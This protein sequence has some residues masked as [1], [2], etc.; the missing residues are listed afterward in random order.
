MLEAIKKHLARIIIGLIVV[1]VFLVHTVSLWGLHIPLLDQFESIIYDTRLRLTMPEGVD[2]RI[3]ILDIDEKSLAE[4]EKG[5]EG[6]WPWPRDRLAAMVDKLFDKYQVAVVG[7]DVVFAERD[8]SSG[9]RVLERLGARELR[10][11]PEFHSVLKEVKPQLEYDDIFARKMRGRPV[12]MGY[13]FSSEE[14]GLAPKKGMLP[15]PIFT[16]ESF[17]G[18][19]VGTLSWTGYTANLDVLQRSA[20]SAGHFNSHTDSDG[21]V[22]RVPMLAEYGG[23]YYEPLSLAMV[24]VL[25]GSPPVKAV[26]PDQAL[27]P[28]GYPDLEWLEVGSLRIPVDDT[29]S[30]LVPYRGRKGSFR[31]YS[32]VDVM[33]ERIDPAELK[34]KIALVGTTA[35]GLLDLRATPVDAVYPGVEVHANMIAGMLDGNIKQRPPYVLG[36]EFMLLL[37][38]GLLLALVLPFVNPLKAT[39]ITLLVLSAVLAGNLTVFEHGH[40]VLPLASGLVMVLLLFTLNMAYGFFIEARGTR[41]ITGL[42]GQYV[43]PELVERMA[44]N[45]EQFS[46]APRAEELSVLFSDVRGFT[47]IS[48]ALTPEDL[49]HYINEYLTTMSLV[50]REQHRGTLDKYIGDAVMAF[51]GAP[52]ADRDHARNA[53][54]AALGMQGEAKKLNEKFKARG[55]P[56]FKIG[57]G[58]NSG[59]M[60]VGDMGSKIRKAYT[61]MGDAVNLGSRL[62]GITKQYGADIIIG[63]GTKALI[64]GFVCRELDRVRV[65]GKAEPVAIFQPLGLE[66]EVG[67][68]KQNEIQLW[69]QVLKY[70][71]AQQWDQ[72]ELQLIDLKKT[73]LDSGLY[74]EFLD[75]IMYL[76]A[77]P[78]GAEW[79][80]VWKFETK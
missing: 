10:D 75:R 48:E 52:V 43:P 65:K 40:L 12:V 29:A 59:V 44:A 78:P 22:R 1:L 62:E 5:G 50:I 63:E 25:L 38:T 4:R 16:A 27:A 47:T 45:P 3:V 72:A 61:V 74:D 42:F 13:I 15:L 6:R 11:V 9:I 18:R 56:T 76:R 36:A 71:R 68:D 53:V 23:A 79:D 33:N 64:S 24:R 28:P 77:N 69:N 35:P 7:F 66:G 73:A 39:L 51:W 49:S 14:A 34:G 8:E 67:E 31:Y 21:I 70:Y 17:A 80:G 30:A 55:W 54:L 57:I 20:A 37:V 26:A 60:R 32:L 46:M 58:V 41:L 19:H 2:S